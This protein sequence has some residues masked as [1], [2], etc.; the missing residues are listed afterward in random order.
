MTRSWLR[1]PEASASSSLPAELL[2]C[3]S[4]TAGLRC[5]R[6]GRLR[7]RQTPN[8]HSRA[9]VVRTDRGEAPVALVSEEE[10][11]RHLREAHKQLLERDNELRSVEERVHRLR[12]RQVELQREQL[13]ETHEE[14][15]KTHELL[16]KTQSWSAEL[17][18]TIREMQATRAWRFAVWL[19]SLRGR[20][21][22]LARIGV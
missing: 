13:R 10:L 2:R 15:V 1:S 12:E 11:R 7:P 8:S 22:R 4:A 18:S 6:Y 3:D 14:L 20:A 9:R 21:R 19:R 16:G 17:E 5:P